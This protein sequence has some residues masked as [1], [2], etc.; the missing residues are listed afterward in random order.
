MDDEDLRSL[1]ASD[2][3]PLPP[4][5]SPDA[6][7]A[8]AGSLRR[9]VLLRNASEA[10]AA[11]LVVVAFSLIALRATHAPLL[12][13]ACGLILAATASILWKLRTQGSNLPPPPADAPTQAHLDHLRASLTRQ[14]ALL[15][16]VPRWYLAPF[17]PGLGCFL[18][19]TLI[20]SP[21]A[22]APP[23]LRCLVGGLFSLLVIAV[24]GG[25]AWLNRAAARKLAREIE[26]LS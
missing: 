3:G 9:A 22:H 8:R 24:F 7:A 19:S 14:Q 5:P 25:I 21:L 13:V 11:A 17:A 12:R 1:W 26:A 6:L 2:P 16:G 18:V 4:P 15:A 23:A 10:G 20:E